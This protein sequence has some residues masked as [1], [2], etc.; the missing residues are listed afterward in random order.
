MSARARACV[1]ELFN[2]SQGCRRIADCL[3]GEQTWWRR[4]RREDARC[5]T[6]TTP[7]EEGRYGVEVAD[8]PWWTRRAHA[9]ASEVRLLLTEFPSS[10]P[11]YGVRNTSATMPA[12]RP[13]TP[14]SLR[15]GSSTPA[16]N[17]IDDLENASRRSLEER[18]HDIDEP[19]F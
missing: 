15:R 12:L 16:D 18:D 11:T 3:R 17:G 7:H 9:D 2:P 6:L 13:P 4:V 1:R 14:R 8:T 10:A 5:L 19:G